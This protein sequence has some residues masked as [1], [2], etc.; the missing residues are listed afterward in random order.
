M[1]PG[2]PSSRNLSGTC[3][4][5]DEYLDDARMLVPR[6]VVQ[7][8]LSVLVQSIHLLVQPGAKQVSR[9]QGFGKPVGS[10]LCS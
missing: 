9:S 6:R 2:S 10:G 4:V 1:T 5:V 8:A 3:A 7:R